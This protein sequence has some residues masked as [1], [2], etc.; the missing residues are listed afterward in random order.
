MPNTR[1]VLAIVA[2][3]VVAAGVS[4]GAAWADGPGGVIENVDDAS[5]DAIAESPRTRD[6]L[7]GFALHAA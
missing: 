3:G 4:A 1:A 2:A 6:D 5:S 7:D